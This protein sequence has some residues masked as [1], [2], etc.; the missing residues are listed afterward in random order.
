MQT[1]QTYA[2]GPFQLDGGA[3]RLA[4]DGDPVAVSDRQ[5]EILRLLISHAGQVLSKDTLIEA[6]WQNVAVSDNSLEQAISSLR[7]TLGPAPDG[8]QYIETLARRGY[9]FN[10]AVTRSV[11]RQDDASLEQLVAPYLAFVEGRAALETLEPD[12]VA[13]ACDVFAHVVEAAPDYAPGHTG[14][15]NAQLLAFEATRSDETPDGQALLA[16]GQHA[17]E[18]CRLDP[19][20]GDAWS[21]LAVVLS[22]TRFSTEATAAVADPDQRLPTKKRLDHRLA[23]LRSH[24]A[25][26]E[27]TVFAGVHEL[28]SGGG[29]ANHVA[30]LVHAALLAAPNRAGRGW[31]IPVEPLLHVSA[32]PAPWAATLTML[33]SSAA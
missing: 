11:M 5:I 6:A 23:T 21:T 16:A 15:A 26:V 25:G 19:G 20:S 33:R 18:A 12:A 4:R 31:T 1:G 10:A 2:F 28:W 32:E 27:A 29:D 22:R 3:R 13:G 14:L 24:G 17:R 30:Q 9:R 8:S 7:R